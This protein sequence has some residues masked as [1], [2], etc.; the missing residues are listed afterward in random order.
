MNDLTLTQTWEKIRELGEKKPAY[1]IAQANK[2]G[3]SDF[4]G[5]DGWYR[6]AQMKSQGTVKYATRKI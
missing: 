3:Y 1:H 4:L 2:R 5:P 6:I